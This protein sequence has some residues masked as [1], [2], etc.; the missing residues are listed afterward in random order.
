[1]KSLLDEASVSVMPQ[2]VK[3]SRAQIATFWN[4]ARCDY[5]AAYISCTKTR[6]DTE[7][8]SLWR[9]AGLVIDENGLV[10]PGKAGFSA[11]VRGENSVR[12]DMMA[13]ALIFI[14]SKL[15]NILACPPDPTQNDLDFWKR[16]QYELDVWFETLPESFTSCWRLEAVSTSND[17]ARA[18]FAE[19]FY[20]IALCAV[21]MQ[22]YHFARIL[23][24]L[25]KPREASTS[26]RSQLRSYREIPEKIV[27]HSR[28]ICAIALG[29]PSGYAQIHMVQPLFVAGQCLEDRAERVVILDLLRGIE[30]DMG[31]ATGYRVTELL[32]EW[33]WQTD[34]PT[35]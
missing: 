8:L 11:Y 14:L 28:E 29:R 16:L 5:T 4:F 24:L 10:I 9:S 23:M 13:N 34:V 20:S 15:M 26:V 22:Q 1:M 30:T 21:T 6:L 7:D 25:H 18:H 33:G 19:I 2:C 35:E 31:W 17:P 27:Y 3:P 32:K 12:E